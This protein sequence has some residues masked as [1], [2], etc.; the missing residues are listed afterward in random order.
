ELRRIVREPLDEVELAKG[1]ALLAGDVVNVLE[2]SQATAGSFA[3]LWV[4]QVPLDEYAQLVPRLAKLTGED[5]HAALQ[6][7]LHPDEETTV[8][9]GDLKTVRPTLVKL[10]LG[11]PLVKSAEP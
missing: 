3:S 2:S 11:P 8:I 9:V 7:T 6:R 10:G 4:E 1:K 5:I